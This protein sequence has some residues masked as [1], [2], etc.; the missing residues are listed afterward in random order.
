MSKARL[1]CVLSIALGLFFTIPLLSI[2]Q[3]TVHAAVVI[4]ELFPK[5]ED[6]TQEFIELYNTGDTSVSMN[7]WKLSNTTGTVKTY[8]LGASPTIDPH[9]YVTFYQPQTGI[10]FAINGDTVVLT[11]DHGTVADSQSFPGMLGYNTPMGR[12][13]DGSGIWVIC[14]KITPNQPNDCPVATP[15]PSPTLT[16]IPSNTPT[17]VPTDA[18]TPTEETVQGLPVYQPPQSSRVLGRITT[19]TPTPTPTDTLFTIRVPNTIAI[20]KP[21]AIQITVVAGVWFILIV[22]ATLQKKRKHKK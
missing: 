17:P 9:G 22:I 1:F 21:L 2:R 14:N 11:N 13:P 16:P 7:Q 18:P 20:S 10:T 4:N 15:S 5:V 3:T 19:P 6:V 12:S 8:V